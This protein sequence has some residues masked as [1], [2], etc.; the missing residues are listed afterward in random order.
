MS[1]ADRVPF[2]VNERYVSTDL[3]TLQNLWPRWLT[4]VQAYANAFVIPGVNNAP[5]SVGSLLTLVLGGLEVNANGTSIDVSRGALIQPSPIAAATD[6][7]ISAMAIGFNLATLTVATP[8]PV[9]DTWCLVQAQVQDVADPT[10]SVDV[11]N[12]S[13]FVSTPGQVKRRRRTLAVTVKSTGGTSTSVPTPDAGNVPIAALFR[14]A[15]GGSVLDAHIVDVRPMLPRTSGTPHHLLQVYARTNDLQGTNASI[16]LNVR[17]MTPH[18][19]MSFVPSSASPTSFQPDDAAYKATGSAAV[20]ANQWW[21][22]YLCPVALGGLRGVRPRHLYAN[23]AGEGMLVLSD[24][25]PRA[26]LR[27]N[28]NSITL[29]APF[30]GFTV[31]TGQATFVAAIRRNSANTGWVPF[32]TLGDKTTLY[33][34]VTADVGGAIPLALFT[35]V[36]TTEL[37][38]AGAK[39]FDVEVA[40]NASAAVV[41]KLVVQDPTGALQRTNAQTID[42]N[43]GGN[44]TIFRDVDLTVGQSLEVNATLGGGGTFQGTILGFRI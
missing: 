26:V 22:L 16:Q 35:A 32:L 18:G 12:G 24:V 36:G 4:D 44:A 28:S 15:G 3:N 21:Y 37:L 19:E 42:S 2:I 27:D 39:S 30:A 25:A 1:S 9:S 29:P 13:A 40:Q 11:W 7:P 20:A 17:A 8:A 38:P 14:P 33:D 31:A 23:Y 41:S 5:V 43:A 34:K 6:D 10:V